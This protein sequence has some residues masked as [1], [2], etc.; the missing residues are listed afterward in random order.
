MIPVFTPPLPF[1]H[2]KVED[3][4]G[5]ARAAVSPKGMLLGSWM[6]QEGWV[7]ITPNSG[8]S[9]G[10]ENGKSNGNWDFRVVNRDYLSSIL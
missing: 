2:R 6:V 3:H 4:P 1:K 7:P 5:L 10:K 9:T 8:E